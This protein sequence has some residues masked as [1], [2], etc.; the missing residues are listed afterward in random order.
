MVFMVGGLVMVKGVTRCFKDLGQATV[1]FLQQN[2][3]KLGHD[4]CFSSPVIVHR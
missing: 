3:C 2:W 4:K 1:F